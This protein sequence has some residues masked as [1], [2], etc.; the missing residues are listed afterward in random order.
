LQNKTWEFFCYKSMHCICVYHNWERMFP[1]WP[2][3]PIHFMH[4][5]SYS[6]YLF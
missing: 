6:F 5:G 4:F 1:S 3:S 2:S